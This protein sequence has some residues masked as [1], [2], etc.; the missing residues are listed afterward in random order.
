MQTNIPGL[1]VGQRVKVLLF[2]DDNV[3]KYNFPGLYLK[4][5]GKVGYIIESG[6]YPF[7]IKGESWKTHL[8]GHGVFMTKTGTILRLPEECLESAE[9][10]HAG[11][12]PGNLNN[13][14]SL[15]AI[16]V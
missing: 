8:Y 10:R 13:E 4:Y 1:L 9:I 12:D 14:M 16:A 3:A 6:E 2:G 5:N 7:V 11:S 15:R